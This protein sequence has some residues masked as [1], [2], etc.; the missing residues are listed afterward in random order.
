MAAYRPTPADKSGFEREFAHWITTDPRIPPPQRNVY[1]GGWELDFYWPDQRVVAETDGE[2]YH[3][4]PADRERD[5]R[6]DAWLQL[7]RIAVLR[8]GEF[9]FEHDRDGVLDDL[10]G[11]LGLDRRRLD[12]APY[13]GVGGPK[14]LRARR[15][16]AADRRALAGI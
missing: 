13:V 12:S 8:V 1:L 15:G 9:R 10:L 2:R 14:A 7:H 11:L 6:K 3:M 5:Y 4:L 16:G